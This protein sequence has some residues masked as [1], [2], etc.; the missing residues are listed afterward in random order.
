M[1]PP[2]TPSPLATPDH[3][4]ALQTIWACQAGKDVYCEKPGSHNIFEGRQMVRAARKYQRIVQH[5]TQCRS[6]EN[7]R[8]GIQ[9]LHEGAIGRVYMARAIAYKVKAGG[10]NQF[11]PV[12]PGLNW[13]LWLGPAPEKPYNRLAIGRWRF[14]KDYGSGQTGDQGVHELD[15]LRWGLGIDTHPSTVQAM[16]AINLFHRA[17]D[18]DTFTNLSMAC[19][20]AERDVIVT[21]ETRDGY[22]NEEAGMGTKYPFVDHQNVVGVVFYGEEGY[23]IFPDYS[24]YYIFL[25]RERRPGPSASEE[26]EPMVNRPHFQNWL[27]AVRSRRRED[28]YAEVE[29]GHVSSA[30]CHLANIAATVG[31]T[32]EF[33]AQEERF[34][35]DDEAN[36]LL[37]PPYR[38]PYLVPDEV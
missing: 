10:K 35:G 8:E 22:T 13:D 11:E 9:K 28:L 18:E 37:K 2:S 16:G 34:R 12:P 21:F 26:G 15:I 32:L 19:R 20:Y 27:S 1:I 38:K 14:L 23:T 30:M 25:G 29:Q 4:H 6:S 33:D 5:G 3:W 17:S 24:S 36:R 7:I 31:R